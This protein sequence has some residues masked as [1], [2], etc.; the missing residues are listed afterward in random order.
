VRTR[1]DRPDYHGVEV[2]VSSVL[3]AQL[4]SA[5]CGTGARNKHLPG[6]VFEAP[7]GFMQGI[8]YGVLAGDGSQTRPDVVSL[9]QTSEQLHWQM[10]TLAA[11]L[12]ADFVSTYCQPVVSD[13]HA[14]SYRANFSPDAGSSYRRTL[15][16]EEFVYKPVLEVIRKDYAGEVFNIEVA[17]DH[18]YVTDFA[19]HNCDR[20][21]SAELHEGL[22]ATT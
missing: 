17:D 10:R 11:R 20:E 19:V 8:F 14:Q 12:N 7:A 6:F 22:I 13:S 9:E 3:L 4:L 2:S 5:L 16:D 15:S 18:S 21:L 1:A